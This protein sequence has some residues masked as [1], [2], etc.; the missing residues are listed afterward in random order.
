M[1]RKSQKEVTP[2]PGSRWKSAF[3]PAV[4]LDVFADERKKKAEEPK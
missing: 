4:R 1:D 3:A 2:P